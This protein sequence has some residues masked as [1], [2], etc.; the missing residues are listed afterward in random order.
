M[1]VMGHGS[2]GT[3]AALQMLY[4]KLLYVYCEIIRDAGSCS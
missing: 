4:V 3:F 1:A 2:N